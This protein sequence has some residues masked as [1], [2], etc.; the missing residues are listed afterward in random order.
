MLDVNRL[1]RLI[2]YEALAARPADTYTAGEYLADLRGGI[3]SEVTRASP[4]V[5]VYRRNL[6]RAYVDAADR[7]IN[8]PALPAN[9]TPQQRA[10]FDAARLSDA[11]ALLR[12]ELVELQRLVQNATTRTNDAMTRLHLRDLNLEITQ[13]LG[14]SR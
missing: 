10:Q 14:P 12:G 4:V 2:E 6:Q 11:R 5:S 3:W 13:I 1:N 9:A 8:P 7:A